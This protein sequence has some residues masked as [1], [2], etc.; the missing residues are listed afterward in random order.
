MKHDLSHANDTVFSR[1][2]GIYHLQKR[3]G[4]TA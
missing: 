2:T 1:G 3:Q 4:M